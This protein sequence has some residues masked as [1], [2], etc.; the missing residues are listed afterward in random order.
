MI[1]SITEVM[2]N[3]RLKVKRANKHIA[4]L[5]ADSAA[6]P[7]ELYEI[8]NGPGRSIAVLRN[9][10]RYEL[11]YLPK[12][13]VNEHFGAVM[14]DAVNNLREAM[15]YWLNNAIE[16]R[17]RKNI[18]GHFPFAREFKDLETSRHYPAVKRAFPE[19]AATI[20]GEIQ[21]CRDTNL[22][23]WAVTSLCNGNKHNDFLPVVIIGNIDKLS[24]RIVGGQ[25][26]SEASFAV[27][28][29]DRK[30]LVRSDRPIEIDNNF[31]LAVDVM[32]PKGAIFEDQPV[33][34]TLTNM[35]QA[36]SETLDSLE[37][38]LRSL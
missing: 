38:F 37:A 25:T 22:H 18:G 29:N 24:I 23:L 27:D 9:P 33:I 31:R 36:V 19:L 8:T 3:P 26:V 10:D 12:E 34:P 4:S 35:S 28:A 32:F 30:N 6:L 15:D 13:P 7:N 1:S 5:I 17:T 20:L 16:W 21:P 14:G 2:K 11:I